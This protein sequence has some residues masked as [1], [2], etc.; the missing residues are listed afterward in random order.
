MS[1]GTTHEL[2]PEGEFIRPRMDAHREESRAP[3]RREGALLS[4]AVPGRL[5]KR[6]LAAA[7]KSSIEVLQPVRFRNDV[8]IDRLKAAWT[9]RECVEVIGGN[10]ADLQSRDFAIARITLNDNLRT[11]DRFVIPC[12]GVAL[13]PH[14]PLY[15]SRLLQ[16]VSCP[17]LKIR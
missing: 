5:R 17:T 13:L 1:S 9:S 12:S 14:D 7:R 15:Q 2:F 10:G 11:N 3:T 4:H 6:F 16:G 8:K